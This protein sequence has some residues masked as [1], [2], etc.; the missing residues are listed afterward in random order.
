MKDN[1]LAS[2]DVGSSK[3]CTLVGELTPDVDLRIL[4]VGITASQGVKKGMVDNIQEATEAIASS[5]EKAERSSG[6]RV[7]S[8][9]VSINGNHVNSLTNRGVATTP[10]RARPLTQQAIHSATAAAPALHLP[11][12][13][14]LPRDAPPVSPLSGPD[15]ALAPAPPP[16]P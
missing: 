9:H 10:G 5:V 6:S 8:A 13:R 12:P 7:L 1:I 4:G 3:I 14:A 16:A 11:T 15:P 2:I